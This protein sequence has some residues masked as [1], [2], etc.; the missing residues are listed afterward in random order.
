MLFAGIF[1]WF[2]SFLFQFLHGVLGSKSALN[3]M[4]NLIYI[5]FV[6][7]VSCLETIDSSQVYM[8]TS[9]FSYE[10]FHPHTWKI[11]LMDTRLVIASF[12]F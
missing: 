1:S 7:L 12:F 6:L 2:L 5:L 10:C 4:S 8:F 3:L 9:V 11:V